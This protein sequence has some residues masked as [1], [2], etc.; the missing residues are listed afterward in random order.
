MRGATSCAKCPT[1]PSARRSVRDSHRCWSPKHCLLGSVP[2]NDAFLSPVA[3]RALSTHQG[4][5][6]AARTANG[7]KTLRENQRRRVTP[8]ERPKLSESFHLESPP[9]AAR[10]AHRTPRPHRTP[11]RSTRSRPTPSRA[12]GPA[13]RTSRSG[14]ASTR[15][16][17]GA[18]RRRRGRL[19]EPGS[20]A[21]PHGAADHT[22]YPAPVLKTHSY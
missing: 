15:S 6:K 12:R 2:K 18:S 17:S 16:S 1:N 11:A 21:A 14:R 5:Q 4:C 8:R 22:L 7:S 10:A 20:L 13:R 9:N 3:A 19:K